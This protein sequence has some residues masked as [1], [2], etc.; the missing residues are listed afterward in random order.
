MSPAL[1]EYYARRARE[2]E[3][4]YDKP[5]RAA[6]LRVLTALL[7]ST[8]ADQHVLEVACGTGYWTERV[9]QVARTITATDAAPETLDVARQKIY[10]PGRVRLE[11]GDA[12]APGEIAGHFTAAFGGFWWSHI[13]REKLSRFLAALHCRLGFGARVVFC[14]NR[15]VGGSSTPITRV[16]PAG[17]TYQRRCLESGEEYEVLKNFPAGGELDSTLRNHGGVDISLLE[18]TYY[19][20]VTYRVGAVT[21]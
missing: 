15:Y 16:D 6:D 8:L 9:A 12:Y 21:L 17:N 13:P 7:Q 3:R 2:Y 10:P 20:C 19:W 18:L 1:L 11:I 14:D 4:I 5:E